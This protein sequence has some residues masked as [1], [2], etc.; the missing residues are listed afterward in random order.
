MLFTGATIAAAGMLS[1]LYIQTV[2]IFIP[3]IVE[4]FLKLR[5]HFK[6]ENYSTTATNGHLEYHGR[7]ESITHVFMRRMRANERSLVTAVWLIEIA[8]CLVVLTTDIVL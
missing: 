5:G 3:M 1:S 2:F 8:L 7:I 4:F 6:A